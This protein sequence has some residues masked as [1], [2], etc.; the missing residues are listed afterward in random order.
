MSRHLLPLRALQAL[1]VAARLGSFARAAEELHVTPAAVSQQI[2]QLEEL[3]GYPLFIREGGGLQITPAAKTALHP[4]GTAFDN[5]E[6]ISVQLRSA[7]TNRPLVVS[8]PPIF[9]A[10]WLIPHLERFQTA[11]PEVELRLLASMRAVN[12]DTEDVDMAVRYGHGR[13]PGLHVERLREETMLVVAHP[14]LGGELHT[15]A[16]LLNANLLHYT[17][18]NDPVFPDWP[19]W[20]HNAGVETKT[21]LRIRE[22]GDINLVIE[23]TLSG[24][25]VAMVWQSLVEADL[26]AGRLISLYGKQ[27]LA[28]AYH[29]VCPPQRLAL[30]GVAAFRDWLRAEIN[31]AK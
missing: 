17:T 5:L 16:D 24:L 21:P 30:P 27:P 20:L 22:F 1:E 7:Q 31:P 26:A 4:L 18:P 8:L 6:R 25:G 23:A 15:P 10:R 11:H 2:K 14:R 13:Y 19:T 3:L 9:A 29:F 12:F 28:N